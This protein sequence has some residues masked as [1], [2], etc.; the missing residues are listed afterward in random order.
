[1]QLQ[2]IDYGSNGEGIAKLDGKVYFVDNALKDEIVEA[3]VTKQKSQFCFCKT[4]SIVKQSK[5][6][7]N[8]KCKYFGKCNGCNLMHIQEQERARVKKQITQN[9]INKI[10]KLD[11]QLND[12]V[13]CKQY[14]YRNKMV[15]AVD[16]N[17]N[18]CMHDKD[19]SLLQVD[20]CHLAEDGINELCN[21][22]ESF[23][24]KNKIVG[25]N[26]ITHQG[27][28]YVVV[29]KLEE[30]Y[31]I[32]LVSTFNKIKNIE[33]LVEELKCKG[34]DFGLFINV[35]KVK[36]SIILTDNFI[37]IYGLDYIEGEY[38]TLKNKVIKYP[39]SCLSFL[40]VNNEIKEKIYKAVEQKLEGS[41]LVIDAYSGAG[42]M[43]AIVAGVAEQ[44]V[45]IEIVKE[46]YEDAEKLKHSNNINNI[47]NINN[48]CLVGFDNVPKELIDKDTSIILDPPRKGADQLVLKKVLNISPSKILYISCNP[49]TLARDLVI[50]SKKYDVENITPYDMFACTS[51]VEV[52]AE[53]KLK[54]G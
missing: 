27:L 38:K 36:G 29:R 7:H 21:I 3:N 35:N 53:L 19:G 22:I 47:Y 26:K 48:D 24:K 37:K 28:R 49:A 46:A 17:G 5:Y 43:T 1:M 12:L 20:Y 16:T 39:I 18:L 51:D 54:R 4:T 45:G 30:K 13:S 6:R 42:L 34:Y 50:L 10:S 41:K 11:L 8:P 52:V 32:A 2:I 33:L 15:F 25:Y 14:N 40:Q 44:V 31:L 23:I 9:T